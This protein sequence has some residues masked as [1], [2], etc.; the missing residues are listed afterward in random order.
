MTNYRIFFTVTKYLG[1]GSWFRVWFPPGF[2][3]GDTTCALVNTEEDL[4]CTPIDSHYLI[5]SGIKTPLTPTKAGDVLYALKIRNVYNPVKTGQT[6]P[7]FTFETMQ[8]GVNTVNEYFKLDPVIIKPG[9]IGSVDISGNPLNKN[10][11]ID[12]TIKF[13]PTNK[14]PVPGRMRINFPLI[15]AYIYNLD[16]SCRV[17]LGLSDEPGK[18]LTCNRVGSDTLEIINFAEFAPQIVELKIFAVNPGLADVFKPFK[19]YTESKFGD[20]LGSFSVIDQNEDAG[21]ITISEVDRPTYV[22]VDLYKKFTNG[23]FSY[24]IPLDFILYPQPGK[25]LSLTAGANWGFVTMQIPLFWRN[26][27]QSWDAWNPNGNTVG[28]TFGGD[29]AS[30]CSYGLFLYQVKTPL[31]TNYDKYPSQSGL[32]QCD[33]P[34]SLANVVISPIP[35]WYPFRAL[36]FK[37]GNH[38]TNTPTEQD[39]FWL[40]LSPTDFSGLNTMLVTDDPSDTDAVLYLT[41]WTS[42]F[43]L[44]YEGSLVLNFTTVDNTYTN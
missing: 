24:T 37:N 28:C 23:T 44:P 22:Q 14:I 41:A 8:N 9:P 31:T 36:T 20:P 26:W 38:Y 29:P 42:T 12:Y 30:T 11:R 13:T 34:I 18:T 35:G 1:P 17:I 27:G 6:L 10:L 7:G 4:I 3:F 32:G 25:E 39:L 33:V 5:V 2:V 19:I 16:S 15:G 43:T 21:Q 40:Y